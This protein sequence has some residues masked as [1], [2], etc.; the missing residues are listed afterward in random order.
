MKVLIVGAGGIGGF[1]GAY[2]VCGGHTVDF[3]VRREEAKNAIL[4]S[5]MEIR[6]QAETFR[7]RPHGVFTDLPKDYSADLVVISVK[8]NAT[9]DVLKKLEKTDFTTIVS[10]QNGLDKYEVLRAAFGRER[11]LGMFSLSFAIAA[12]DTAVRL[13]KL[14][15]TYV[16]ALNPSE[17]GR[18]RE[19]AGIFET[20][21][22]P[23]VLSED[24]LSCEWSK[25]AHWIP[26][27][28]ISAVAGC[29]FSEV[30]SFPDLRELYLYTLREVAAVA[31][32]AGIAVRDLEDFEPLK[33][34]SMGDEEALEYLGKKGV[35][36]E[37][38]PLSRYKQIM[39]QDLEGRRKTEM[40]ETGGFVERKAR[41]LS[42]PVPYL[43][44]LVKIIRYRENKN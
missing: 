4:A 30:F 43:S 22:M 9:G 42:V 11:V 8:G 44:G 1:V 41:A 24:I 25:K 32:T 23:A 28:L 3:L 34:T 7:V 26:V 39:L 14:A 6:G 27:S 21:G 15:R 37:G 18:A 20:A 29:Y 36:L 40:E 19:I 12:G 13:E 31:K 2:L 35:L 17:D 10:L 33:I 5:G 16:G 38:T